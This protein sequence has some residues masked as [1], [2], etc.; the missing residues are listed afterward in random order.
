MFSKS[1]EYGLRSVLY[2]AQ[3]SGLGTKVGV[4]DISEAINS[5]EAFTGKILQKLVKSDIIT[6][7]KGRWGGFTIDEKLAKNT[8]ISKVVKA[9]DGNDVYTG[10]GLGL[11]KCDAQNPCP[12]HDRFLT[13]RN[14]LK[15]MLEENTVYD[16]VDS[17][18]EI[19]RLRR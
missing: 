11:K 6:S 18:N 9:I 3:Q 10:C 1:C 2:I 17:N 15:Q 14:D 4:K 16:L 13:I 8:S 7:V 5:P 12:L 19:I